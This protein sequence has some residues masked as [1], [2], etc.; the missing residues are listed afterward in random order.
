M[1]A[2]VTG[3]PVAA[4]VTPFVVLF[5]N[6]PDPS[7]IGIGG[8]GLPNM[9]EGYVAVVW[10]ALGPFCVAEVLG[11]DPEF[12]EADCL[13]VK[14]FLARGTEVPLAARTRKNC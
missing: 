1:P 11:T 12:R 8:N 5:P 10:R 4:D 14:R 7:L 2:P 9:S 3:S 13:A 6:K